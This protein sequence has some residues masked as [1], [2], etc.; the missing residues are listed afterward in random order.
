MGFDP[1]EKAFDFASDTTKQLL[2]LSTAILALTITFL[3]DV[4][5]GSASTSDKVLLA[6][7]WA[8]FLVSIGAGLVTMMALTAELEPKTGTPNPSIRGRDVVRASIVQAL[9]FL[10]GAL[11]IL[12]FAIKG[13]AKL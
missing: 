12:V 7:S 2:T 6:I 5:G 13:V 9:T 4:L 8:L 10:G 3:K 11:F 1:Q